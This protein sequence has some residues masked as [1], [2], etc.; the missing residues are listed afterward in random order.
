MQPARALKQEVLGVPARLEVPALLEVL[1]RE[2]L[3][4]PALLGA[5]LEALGA[6]SIGA[7][8]AAAASARS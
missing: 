7:A 8:A 2:A 4:V 5:M 6:R 1:E 3:G